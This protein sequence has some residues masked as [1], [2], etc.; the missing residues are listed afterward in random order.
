MM[1][2]RVSAVTDATERSREI[3]DAWTLGSVAS[4]YESGGRGP[5]T[6]STGQGD[7]GGVSYGTY[8]LSSQQP[9][10]KP[11]TVYEYLAQSR[12]AGEF[13]GLTPGTDEFTD[14]WKQLAASEP[15]F[16][17][18]QHTFINESH[19]GAVMADLERRGIDLSGRGPAV[20][21]AIISTATQYRSLTDNI[22]TAGVTRLHGAD[23]DVS[24]LTDTQLVIAIQT[25]KLDGNDR[26][27]ASSS[28]GVRAGVASRIPRELDDLL[29]LARADEISRSPEAFAGIAAEEAFRIENPLRSPLRDGKLSLG[30]QGPEIGAVQRQLGG[31]GYTN[32]RGE[33]LVADDDFGRG[34]EHAV[35]QFQTDQG[36]PVTGIADE[37]T[38]NALDRSV[39]ESLR[40]LPPVPGRASEQQTSPQNPTQRVEDALYGPVRDQVYAMD[41]SLGRTPD[42]AS[43]RVAAAL[44]AEWRT[45][46]ARGAIDGVVLGQKGTKAEA[47][48]YVFAYSGSPERPNDFVGVRTSDA[49][50]TPVEQ[51]MAKAQE[52]V[53]RQALEA[54]QYAQAQQQSADGPR[55]TMG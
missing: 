42:E 52:A 18:E 44:V 10:G 51:S 43:D 16:G 50:Q 53:H 20:Q 8:Q 54:Q 55:M 21:E 31:L 14:K 40:D 11:G 36:L 6:V 49:V 46:Q 1:L 30:E 15:A 39:M 48:E 41:R 5:G 33:L 45:D 27:F 7:A 25:E 47:G 17:K 26:Y 4:R 38:R 37:A 12:F 29:M 13:E 22:I 28:A 23:A 34:T 32:A 35:T 2:W 9:N 3:L 19:Y 24:A